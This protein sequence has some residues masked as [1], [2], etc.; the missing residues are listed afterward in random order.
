MLRVFG[1]TMNLFASLLARRV[2]RT[3]SRAVRAVDG[4][5]AGRELLTSF[6]AGQFEAASKD[7]G[8][9][10]RATPPITLLKTVKHDLDEQAGAF[11]E[12]TE[13][14]TRGLGASK[15]SSSSAPTRR[16]LLKCG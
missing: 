11:Q 9:Q 10:M 14:K 6:N 1:V 2:D 5:Q 16:G 8:D 7:F 15:S 12:V 4:R 3:S 13:T